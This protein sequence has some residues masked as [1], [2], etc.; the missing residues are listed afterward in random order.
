MVGWIVIGAGFFSQVF[1][2]SGAMGAIEKFLI[3]SKLNPWVVFMIAQCIVF[4]AG[5]LMDDVAII[6][7]FG[8]LFVSILNATTEFDLLWFGVVFNINLQLSLLTPPFGFALFY[9]RGMAPKGVDMGEVYRS[10]LPFIVIQAIV[11][12][13]SIMYP[14]LCTWLPNLVFD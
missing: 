7:L 8:P 14:S 11:M 10:S 5:C 13:C 4:I 9:M 6:T 3:E 1:A 2:L 12:V